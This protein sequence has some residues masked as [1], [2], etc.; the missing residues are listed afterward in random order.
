MPGIIPS[1]PAI[2]ISYILWYNIV[3]FFPNPLCL[4]LKRNRQKG[5]KMLKKVVNR[6]KRELEYGANWKMFFIDV[7]TLPEKHPVFS[8]HLANSY[9]GATT[10]LM[11][12]KVLK[13]ALEAS[14]PRIWEHPEIKSTDSGMF[15]L[16]HIPAGAEIN[17]V[18]WF[19]TRNFPLRKTELKNI[20]ELLKEHFCLPL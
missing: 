16:F 6:E 15:K 4:I 7:K 18:L 5:N 3:L 12:A 2:E 1:P 14:S 19:G 8:F 10:A 9:P 13:E 17:F 20:F 11:L